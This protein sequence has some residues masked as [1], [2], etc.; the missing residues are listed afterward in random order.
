M[1]SKYH[2]SVKKILKEIFPFYSIKE[3]VSMYV[4]GKTKNKEAKKLHVDLFIKDMDMA[5]EV[6]GQHHYEEIDYG[7]GNG[8]VNFERRRFLDNLKNSIAYE[9]G[10]LMIR[11]PYT[12][13]LNREY[14]EKQIEIAFKEDGV[15]F[16]Y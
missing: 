13:A 6:D 8:R 15:D 16:D 7:D 14:V 11:I 2:K 1:A 5:I 12:E 10:W 3:E 9:N 4:K